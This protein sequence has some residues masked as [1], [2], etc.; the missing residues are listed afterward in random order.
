MLIPP[1]YQ[2]PVDASA[3]Y[4]CLRGLF[5]RALGGLVAI[6]ADSAPQR[7]RLPSGEVVWVAVQ[8]T[9]ALVLPDGRDPG[10]TD[11]APDVGGRRRR[12]GE[13][14]EDGDEIS[15]LIGFTEAVS[16]IAHSVRNS[17]AAVRPNKVEVEFG[18]EID[19]STGKVVSLV[20]SAHAKASIK[21]KLAWDHPVAAPQTD[22]A[23]QTDPISQADQITQANPIT[24]ATAIAEAAA[25]G[26]ERVATTDGARREP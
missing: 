1:L 8:S 5:S 19:G 14:A 22:P 17:L 13:P 24:E 18:L 16:G 25:A 26:T 2:F 12:G 6:D 4:V 3:N 11:T 9:E 20:A 10:D 21:V 15:R 23:G 7:V